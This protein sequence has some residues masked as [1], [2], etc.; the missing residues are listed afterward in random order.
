MCSFITYRNICFTILLDHSSCDCCA[1]SWWITNLHILW[2]LVVRHTCLLSASS[3][4][5]AAGSVPSCI[6][7]GYTDH[8]GGVTSEVLQL[9]A[10]FRHEQGP[11][12]LCLILTLELPKVN[13]HG[14]SEAWINI[15]VCLQL[16]FGEYNNFCFHKTPTSNSLKG[17]QFNFI[18]CKCFLEQQT[19]PFH[20]KPL[21]KTVNKCK[22]VH[23]MVINIK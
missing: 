22:N 6:E 12:P 1:H 19:K 14:L 23:L 11:Q 10:S 4:R 15:N 18:P 21:W 5:W 8:V 3:R 13:L 20:W 2:Y 17:K 16:L 7:R 9:H